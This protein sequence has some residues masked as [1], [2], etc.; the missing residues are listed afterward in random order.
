MTETDQSQAQATEDT[1]PSQQ[2]GALEF[3]TVPPGLDPLTANLVARFASALAEKLKGAQDKYGYTDG[4]AE[5]GWMDECRA[6]LREHVENGDPRDVAAFAA[7]LWH[8][9]AS[10]AEAPPAKG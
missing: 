3:F 4:W 2:A 6:Q 7:F 5:P 8:H 9:G 1:S 10:T